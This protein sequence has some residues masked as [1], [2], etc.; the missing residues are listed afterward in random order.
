MKIHY[1]YDIFSFVVILEAYDLYKYSVA[2]SLAGW[3]K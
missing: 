1:R 2:I 3:E